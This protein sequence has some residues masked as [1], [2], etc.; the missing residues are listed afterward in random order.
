MSK[1]AGFDTRMHLT[2]LKNSEA[3]FLLSQDS[4]RLLGSQDQFLLWEDTEMEFKEL[5][6]KE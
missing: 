2:T 4:T 1:G 6:D 5:T 3:G